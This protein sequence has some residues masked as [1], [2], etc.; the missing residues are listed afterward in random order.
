MSS[1]DVPVTGFYMSFA[2]ADQQ[3][4]ARIAAI[5]GRESVGVATDDER[6]VGDSGW[7]AIVERIRGCE[8][9]VAVLSPDWLES[10]KCQAEWQYAVASDKPV[11]ALRVG[12]RQRR[13]I[14]ALGEARV[15]DFSDTGSSAAEL[16]S[17]VEAARAGI[18]PEAVLPPQPPETPVELSLRHDP[19]T[20]ADLAT[21]RQTQVLAQLRA[22]ADGDAGAPVKRGEVV[23]LL[24]LLHDH[25]DVTYPVQRESSELLRSLRSGPLS[26]WF[27]AAVNG[28]Q[29]HRAWA[30][31]AAA[32][33]LVAAVA[34]AVVVVDP[35]RRTA[36]AGWTQ[37][38]LVH[39]LLTPTDIDA[40]ADIEGMYVAYNS[41]KLDSS[42]LT[43]DDVECS[44][45]VGTAMRPFYG[46]FDPTG[47]ADQLMRSGKPD[48]G[49]PTVAQTL[50]AFG[51]DAVAAQVFEDADTT[52][53][54]CAGRTLRSRD[55]ADMRQEVGDVRRDG[56]T[57]VQTI[58]VKSSGEII[59]THT[60]SLVDTVIAE[61]YACAVPAEVAQKVS[62]GL[63]DRVRGSADY[64]PPIT[65]QGGQLASDLLTP[66]ELTGLQGI[67]EQTLEWAG[68][69]VLGVTPWASA[70][71]CAGLLENRS[72][73][74]YAGTMYEGIAAQNTAARDADGS[75]RRK[76][77]QTVAA[78]G[79]GTAATALLQATAQTWKRCAGKDVEVIFDG[80]DPTHW[81]LGPV[82]DNGSRIVQI[83]TEGDTW[84]C[85]H[86]MSAVGAKVFEAIACDADPA[87][88]SVRIVDQM[89][90]NAAGDR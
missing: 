33:V 65:G 78:F 42:G 87:G 49:E 48:S 1:G 30:N 80:E 3:D 40:A 85:E 71:E 66:R 79:S 13:V 88:K 23:R 58:T 19:S 50:I 84:G 31:T 21:D 47:V 89:T 62:S 70:P 28:I 5:L 6:L 8:V 17:A 74:T 68:Q 56:S 73:A 37:D 54:S 75:T 27:T 22:A 35:F 26:E 45:S 16:A 82:A 53:K 76:V 38:Q 2:A 34:V 67:D 32:V 64:L 43:P 25:P 61:A 11:L 60:M 44:Q 41:V 29:S 24:T 59:C 10:S 51:S 15:V 7:D 83:N 12:A 77:Y 55:D 9:F 18:R 39:L 90:T 20:L 86:V 46:G 72:W 63:V 36:E 81:R 57:L 52:L 14:P 4:A 69:S